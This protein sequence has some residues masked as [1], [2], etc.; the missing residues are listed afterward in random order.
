MTMSTHQGMVSTR[1]AGNAARRG[2]CEAAVLVPVYRRASGALTLV[3]VRKTQRGAHGGQLA[4]P[5][6]HREA[7][8]AS[9]IDTALREA[10]EEVGLEPSRVRIIETLPEVIT[11]TTGCRIAPYL[12]R[13]ERPA[14]WILD[15]EEI[16]EVLEIE[17]SALADPEVHR[18]EIWQ[19]PHWPEPRR[20][21]F[22]SV[23]DHKLWGA[24]YRI[25][26][27]LLPRLSTLR[28]D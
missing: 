23:C 27:P 12:A 4:F 20:V 26:H 13:V 8:D 18:S 14:A 22:Y 24:S 2:E 21:S 5:G 7:R 15:T 3:L 6:G 28:W 17:I 9:L 25:L 10:H 19:L 1:T 11:V 16:A